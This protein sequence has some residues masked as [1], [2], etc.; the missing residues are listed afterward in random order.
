MIELIRW[1]STLLEPQCAILFALAAFVCWCVKLTRPALA[2]A[3][4]SVW[5][6]GAPLLDRYLSDAFAAVPS[7]M[8]WLLLAVLAVK[9]L[10]VVIIVALG[11]SLAARVL[12]G[13]VEFIGKCC[14]FAVFLP[15]RLFALSFRDTR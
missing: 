10:V 12:R 3:G 6:A 8:L 2:F 7:W 14:W 13:C 15:L 1:L 4:I 9:F 11:P 5:L